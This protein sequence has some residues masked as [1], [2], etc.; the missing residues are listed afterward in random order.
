MQ[1]TQGCEPAVVEVGRLVTG[2]P[3][4][5]CED[6]PVARKEGRRSWR[7]LHVERFPVGIA[8]AGTNVVQFQIGERRHIENAALVRLQPRLR[9]LIVAEV[10][11]KLPGL[12]RLQVAGRVERIWFG[13]DSALGRQREAG[14]VAGCTAGGQECFLARAG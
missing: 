2:S 10:N 3:K 13:E 1:L 9:E 14:Y 4:L 7:V 5:L 8:G 12:A 6:L 11:A